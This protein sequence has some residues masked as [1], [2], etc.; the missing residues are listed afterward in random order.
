M[1]K[2][3]N[4]FHDEIIANA[5]QADDEG[6][7]DEPRDEPYS[8]PDIHVGVSLEYIKSFGGDSDAFMKDTRRRLERKRIPHIL[9]LK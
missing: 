8:A 3:K 2:V 6:Q 5:Q 9:M 1:G 4:H 7:H